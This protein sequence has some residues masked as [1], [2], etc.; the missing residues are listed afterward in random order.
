MHIHTL[1]FR[2]GVAATEQ[3]LI[4]AWQAGARAQYRAMFQSTDSPCQTYR[5][6]QVCGSLPLRAPTEE[7]EVAPNIVGTQGFASDS[8]PTWLARVVSERTALAGRS[9][10]GRFYIGGLYESQHSGNNL[11]AGD[12]ALVQAYIDALMAA[13]VTGVTPGADAYALVVH[14]PTLA[15]VPATN[16][17]DSST[18]VTGMIARSRVGSMKSRKPGSGT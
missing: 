18:P 16:C 14:S 4:D 10:R 12:L 11:T 3:G 8:S 15:A 6:A 2:L 7:T 9:R 13:F 17:Q 1:H 5:A